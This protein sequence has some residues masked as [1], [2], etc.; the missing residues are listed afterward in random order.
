MLT[1]FMG[2]GKTT[3]GRVLSERLGYDFVDTDQMIEQRHGPVAT[4]FADR[5][6]DAFRAIERAV[7]AELAERTGLVIATGGRM[8]LDEANAAVLGRNGHVVCLVAD[9]DTIHDRIASEYS[10]VIRPLLAG[11]HPRARIEELMAERK[12]GYCRFTQIDTDGRSPEQVADA[13]IAVI[14]DR[15]GPASA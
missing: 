10:G 12:T 1:G 4:I 9:P 5:G 8:M 3:V 14:S 6:E 13:V 15:P 2:T 11:D 7:A